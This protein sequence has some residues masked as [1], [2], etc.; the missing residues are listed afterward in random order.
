MREDFIDQQ[1][2]IAMAL[3]DIAV[4][5][6]RIRHIRDDKDLRK[7]VLLFDELQ[8]NRATPALRRLG[9]WILHRFRRLNVVR[10]HLVAQSLQVRIR[11]SVEVHP[12]LQN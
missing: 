3:T 10:Y 12:K 4:P 1:Y 11:D 6:A 5:Q 8:Q 9:L 7:P 2:G